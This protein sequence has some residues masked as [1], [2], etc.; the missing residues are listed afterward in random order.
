MVAGSSEN[1]NFMQELIWVSTLLQE[2]GLKPEEIACFYAMPDA[3]AYFADQAQFDELTGQ[4]INCRRAERG[5]VLRTIQK[6]LVA[7]PR[8][9]FLYVT[10]HGAPPHSNP[11]LKNPQDCTAYAS[12]LVIDHGESSCERN[13]N[14]TPEAV[15]SIVPEGSQTHKVMV[16][17]GCFSGGFI[18]DQNDAATAPSALAQL[19]NIT[20]LTAARS[21]RPSFGCSS[22]D[23][24]TFYGKSF[25]KALVDEKVPF[26]QINWAAVHQRAQNMTRFMEE[27]LRIVQKSEPQFFSRP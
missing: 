20:L 9:F 24:A 7:E 17:Q 2:R 1:A 5:E 27:K 19:A 22:G 12:S 21:D 23:T 3:L 16:F 10:S 26:H 18:S 6:A 11:T 15:A 8:D 13:N 14:I 4:V 25:G